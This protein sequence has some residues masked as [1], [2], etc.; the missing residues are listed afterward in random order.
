MICRVPKQEPSLDCHFKSA[1]NAYDDDT[2]EL[3]EELGFAKKDAYGELKPDREHLG[4]RW[5]YPA[6]RDCLHFLPTVAIIAMSIRAATNIQK[7]DRKF[8]MAYLL[9]YNAGM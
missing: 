9:K 6:E 3:L 2:L 7:C 1:Q 8:L 5:Y 4:G